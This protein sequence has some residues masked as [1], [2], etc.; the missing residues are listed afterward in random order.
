MGFGFG[1]G[2]GLGLG[3]IHGRDPKEGRE[4]KGDIGR[5]REI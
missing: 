5:H 2:L 4:I 1:F 3:E